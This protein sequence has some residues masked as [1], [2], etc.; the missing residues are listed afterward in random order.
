MAMGEG[1]KVCREFAD[2][3]A[4]GVEDED[5]GEFAGFGF[6]AA[7]GLNNGSEGAVLINLNVIEADVVLGEARIEFCE[8]VSGILALA[9]DNIDDFVAAVE[10]EG[11]EDFL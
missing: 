3:S 5:G 2:E 4:F 8:E 11:F 6:V 10:A 9:G 7:H 1:E